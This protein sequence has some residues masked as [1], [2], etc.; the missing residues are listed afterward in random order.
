MKVSASGVAIALMGVWKE[1]SYGTELQGFREDS[2]LYV[3]I[4][5]FRLLLAVP[6]I[7]SYLWI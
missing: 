6:Q 7:S 2:S 3:T 1:E 5:T 4:T